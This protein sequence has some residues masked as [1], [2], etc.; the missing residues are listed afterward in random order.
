MSNK[1]RVS[2]EKT[3]SDHAKNQLSGYRLGRNVSCLG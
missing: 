2:K 3:V 1:M